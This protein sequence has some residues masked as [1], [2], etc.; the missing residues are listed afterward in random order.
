MF[1]R[2]KNGKGFTLIELLIVLVIIGLLA[3]LVAP[4]MFRQEEKAKLRTTKTQIELL[5]GALDQYRLDVG[6]YPASSEGLAALQTNPGSEGWDGPYLKKKNIPEDAWGNP[7]V[8]RSPGDQG[9]YDLLSYGP[10]GVEGGD[11]ITS[12]E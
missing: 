8:Y 7:Y 6:N 2:I 5:G 9:D 12:W 4:R 3:G 11:D 10:D 1:E